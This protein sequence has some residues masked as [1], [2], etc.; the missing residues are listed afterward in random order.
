MINTQYAF[1]EFLENRK[2]IK[3]HTHTHLFNAVPHL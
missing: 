1:A 3:I 2:E